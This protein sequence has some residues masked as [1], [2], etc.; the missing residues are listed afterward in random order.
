MSGRGDAHGHRAIVHVDRLMDVENALRMSDFAV[1]RAQRRNDA[2]V[3]DS[4]AVDVRFVLVEVAAEQRVPEARLRGE[5]L[6]GGEALGRAHLSDTNLFLQNE[7]SFDEQDFLDDG[8]DGYVAFLANFGDVFEPPSDRHRFDLD[9]LAREVFV[10]PSFARNCV[11]RD[12]NAAGLHRLFVNGELLGK[13]AQ[14]S[15]LVQSRTARC[16]SRIRLKHVQCFV[17]FVGAVAHGRVPLPC[18][19]QCSRAGLLSIIRHTFVT[20][21]A[22]I[23]SSRG[24]FA[25]RLHDSADNR[26]NYPNAARWRADQTEIFNLLESLSFPRRIFFESGVDHRPPSYV[27]YQSFRIEIDRRRTVVEDFLT[28]LCV[29]SKA[30]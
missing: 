5:R 26:R 2:A 18:A 10:N 9:A 16:L 25:R 6:V 28:L 8:N 19:C 17:I 22:G 23:I 27:P 12:M 15:G 1:D 14:E 30:M 29:R 7:P 3:G 13:Q 11:R 24:F 20:R 4:L 21:S